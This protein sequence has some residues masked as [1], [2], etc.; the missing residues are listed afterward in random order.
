MRKFFEK[1]IT[2]VKEAFEQNGG[3]EAMFNNICFDAG[4]MAPVLP[5]IEETK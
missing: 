1:I 5:P 3:Q 4:V 2:A